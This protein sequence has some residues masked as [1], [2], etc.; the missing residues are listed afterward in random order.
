M[1]SGHWL[2]N[3][4]RN[5]KWRHKTSAM[6]QACPILKLL[7]RGK[8]LETS[9]MSSVHVTTPSECDKIDK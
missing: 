6:A 2:S 5:V 8:I 4:V 1:L 3:S 7:L 9:L